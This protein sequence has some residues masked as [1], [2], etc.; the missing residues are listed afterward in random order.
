MKVFKYEVRVGEHQG[1]RMPSGA[2][3]LDMQCQ[4]GDLMVWAAVDPGAPVLTRD[5][6]VIGTGWELPGGK[7]SYVATAQTQDGLVWHLFDGGE[8]A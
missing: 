7:Q 6:S 4:G 1:L 3:L 8:F 5:L 2:V